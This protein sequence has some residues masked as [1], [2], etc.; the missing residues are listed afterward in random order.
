[1]RL[2]IDSDDLGL[3]R[4]YVVSQI[5]DQQRLELQGRR[6]P[7]GPAITISFQTGAGA[8]DVARELAAILQKPLPAGS[9]PW[10]VFDRQLIE[11]VLEEHNLPKDLARHMPEDRRS[12]I[13]DVMEE[14]VGLR[15]PSWVLVP[16]ITETVLHL[17][18]AG[19]VILVGRGAAL[20]TERM[21]N[22]FHLRLIAP[23]EQRI[24]RIQQEEHLSPKEAA[25]FV[26]QSDRGRGRY[27]KTHFHARAGDELQY[28][29][30]INTGRIP[31]HET[32][33]LVAQA[34]WHCFKRQETP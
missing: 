16:H 18:E 19:H 34:A 2:Q 30:V 28:H 7:P 8:H 10:A 25:K 14:F 17:A 26:E 1:M 33:E 22:V 24:E 5:E 21:P 20:I 32:A 3:C 15:P 13:Q 6:P 9:P 27:M 12:Y 31:M 11:K 23:L 4:S 29:L